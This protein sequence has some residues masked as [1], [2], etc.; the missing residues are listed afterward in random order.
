MINPPCNYNERDGWRAQIQPLD[1]EILDCFSTMNFLQ[2]FCLPSKK[3]KHK[4]E[5]ARKDSQ[6]P[7]TRSY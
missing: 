4:K 5:D 2:I 1:I 7:F 6:A 3:I